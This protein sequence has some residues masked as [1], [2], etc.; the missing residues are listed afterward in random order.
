MSSLTDFFI[1]DADAWRDEAWELVR[2]CTNLDFLILTKRPALISARLPKDWGKGWPNIWLGTTCGVRK[3]YSR[4]DVLRQIPAQV[5]FIS[6]EPLLE[7][8]ADIELQGYQW[9]IAGGESGSG[10][11]PMEETW[12]RELRD[13]CVAEAVGFHFKQ[14]SAFRSGTG[15]KLDGKLWRQPPSNLIQIAGIIQSGK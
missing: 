14:H 4:M 2:H 10:Y 13:K 5:R 1:K 11:R 15:E 12:A 3:S 7:S 6:A 9:L 8:L